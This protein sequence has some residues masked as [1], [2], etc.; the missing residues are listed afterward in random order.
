MQYKHAPG[1]S[2]DLDKNLFEVGA[3]VEHKCPDTEEWR[4]AIVRTVND[5]QAQYT[6][7]L[8]PAETNRH[9]QT[10][11]PHSALRMACAHPDCKKH[12]LYLAALPL[13]CDRCR[14]VGDAPTPT[15]PSSL[16]PLRACANAIG[17]SAGPSSSIAFFCG[18]FCAQPPYP[19]RCV[20]A[21]VNASAAC[22]LPRVRSQVRFAHEL[23]A[24][25][26]YVRVV[27]AHRA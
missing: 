12:C 16:A 17:P 8:E 26:Q 23:P 4:L 11:V 6:I 2:P 14:K 9:K 19:T 24:S 21:H 13:F 1:R 5:E 22:V 27:A 25:V 20:G 10:G 3:Y 18:D 15:H 7:Q